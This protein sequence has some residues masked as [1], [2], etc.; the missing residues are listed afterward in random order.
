M[1]SLLKKLFASSLFQ[2]SI[3][4]GF[5]QLSNL[6]TPLILVPYLLNTL[7][8]AQYGAFAFLQ[9]LME[10]GFLLTDY[11]FLLSATKRVAQETSL[12][13]KAQL[14]LHVTFIKVAITLLI[15]LFIFIT[16]TYLHVKEYEP[17]AFISLFLVILSYSIFPMWYFQGIE[18]FKFISMLNALSKAVLVVFVLTTVK[19]ANDL[20]YAVHAYA[21][22]YA[23]MGIFGMSYAIYTLRPALH[24]LLNV[25]D[26]LDSKEVQGLLKEGLPF[27]TSAL[28]PTLY[29]HLPTIV[30]KLF[31]NNL[32]VGLFS[33]SFKVIIIAKYALSAFVN[34]IYPRVC[35]KATQLAIKALNSYI[36]KVYTPLW[37]SCLFGCIFIAFFAPW[38]GY[39]IG[40]DSQHVE[41][42]TKLLRILSPI[43][44]IVATHVWFSLPLIAYGHNQ[45]FSRAILSGGILALVWQGICCLFWQQNPPMLTYAVSLGIVFTEIVIGVLF[46]I[47]YKRK[48]ALMH[49]IK[50]S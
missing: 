48:Y 34:V 4:S 42:F 11:G 20:S 27:F 43:P 19:T 3:A 13:R 1:R 15:G 49:A 47:G 35:H 31:T 16:F 37:I 46:Y 25:K 23:F 40:V 9:T 26:W 17:A 2:N 29:T 30:L 10:Y 39:L 44:L 24:S 7:G 41:M 8:E 18:K 12:S 21:V 45:V 36:R 50:T 33:L 38:V 14:L 22:S 6:L 32:L 5:W 28:V